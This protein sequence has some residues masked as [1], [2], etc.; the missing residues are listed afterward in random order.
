MSIKIKASYTRDAEKQYILA[1]FREEIQR[2]AVVKAAP[3]GQY[4]RLYITLIDPQFP[5]TESDVCN[6]AQ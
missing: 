2:G 1:K 5:V 3:A 4:K 6:N